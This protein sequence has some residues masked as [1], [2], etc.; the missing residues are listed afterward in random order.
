[1]CF[2]LSLRL[3][4]WTFRYLETLA[5]TLGLPGGS[6]VKKMPANAGDTGFISGSGRSLGEGHGNPLQNSCLENS[7]D[8]RAWWATV[9]EVTKSWTPL[10][11]MNTPSHHHSFP[12]GQTHWFLLPI[13]L[14]LFSLNPSLLGFLPLMPPAFCRCLFPP[15]TGAERSPVTCLTDSGYPATFLRVDIY[16]LVVTQTISYFDHI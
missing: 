7:M 4:P 14:R 11:Q 10:K 9:H 12:P 1:M 16:E 3:T 13:S 15:I 6:V 5:I 2:F 8:R